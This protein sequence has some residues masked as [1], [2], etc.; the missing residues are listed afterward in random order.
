MLCDIRNLQGKVEF[1]W[2]SINTYLKTQPG[3]TMDRILD[4]LDYFDG[5][6]FAPNVTCNTIMSIGLVDNYAPPN[7]EY[8]VYNS[9]NVNKHIMIFKDLAHDASL[10]YV[11]FEDAWMHDEFGLY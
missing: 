10:L 5:K 3:L 7:N 6:N 11:K 2:R 9:L 1:P 4:N 8:A